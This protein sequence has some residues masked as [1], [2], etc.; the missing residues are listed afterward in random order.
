[1]SESPL[2]PNRQLQESDLS[3]H[4]TAGAREN[5][6]LEFKR[7]YLPDSDPGKRKFLQSISAF[8]NSRGGDLILGMEEDNGGAARLVPLAGVD[9]DQARLQIQ[10]LIRV[11]LRP[12]L[13]GV[14][15]ESVPL[16]SGG[17]VLV[18]RVPKSWA[19]RGG[20]RSGCWA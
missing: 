4:I 14:Q 7:E 10:N 11:H 16:S 3:A 19:A 2:P 8:A 15:V 18:V 9:P 13:G 6:F 12:P 1:M 20:V 17:F 5:R